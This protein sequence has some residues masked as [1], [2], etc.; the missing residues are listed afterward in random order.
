MFTIELTLHPVAPASMPEPLQDVLVVWVPKDLEEPLLVLAYLD[1]QRV[2]R[3]APSGE[4]VDTPENFTHWAKQPVLPE[5]L[6][7]HTKLPVIARSFS[8]AH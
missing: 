3:W 4:A 2:W 1:T 8:H 7:A 6:V 5:D